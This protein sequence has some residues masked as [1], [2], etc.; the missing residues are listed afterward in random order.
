MA[1]S[2]GL[3]QA[4][5]ATLDA[6]RSAF[7]TKYLAVKPIHVIP[8]ATPAG[9]A[10]GS[11]HDPSLDAL[12]RLAAALART[13]RTPCQIRPETFDL[14]IALDATRKQLHSTAILQQLERRCDPGA[15]VLGVTT[16]D[17]YVPVLTFV[18]GEA[19]L[20]GNCAVVSTARLKDEFYGLPPREDLMRERLLKEAAHELG[21]TF[22]LRHCADWRCVMTSSHAV[23]RLDVKGTEFCPACQKRV[24]GDRFW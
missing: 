16:A 10:D 23:E 11:A 1:T 15:R 3:E 22:G 7:R 6:G 8:L 24:R 20:E 4:L 14:S 2:P 18:F 13:F 17:L 19:Q 21:H 12:E 5:R 9:Y